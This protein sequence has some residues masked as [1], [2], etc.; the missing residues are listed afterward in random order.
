MD[1]SPQAG[2]KGGGL[3]DL[4]DRVCAVEG[5]KRLKLERPVASLSATLIP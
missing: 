5:F 1:G 3:G 4:G 2:T